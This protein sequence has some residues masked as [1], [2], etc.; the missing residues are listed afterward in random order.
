M[1][2]LANP[3]LARS[4]I[5]FAYQFMPWLFHV[6]SSS[7]A[8]KSSKGWPKALRL[9]LARWRVRQSRLAPN[10][11]LIAE[12]RAAL[13]TKP[14]GAKKRGGMYHGV[15]GQTTLI[16]FPD[17]KISNPRIQRKRTNCYRIQA[18][19]ETSFW[20]ILNFASQVCMPL[21]VQEVPK[22]LVSINHAE[23]H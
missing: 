14:W 6:P 23:K 3:A 20:E 5:P 21:V 13:I 9:T 11:A 8:W 18:I 17:I 7:Q 2:Q 15:W 10:T 12:M 19:N 16:S 1:V 22:R 4:R